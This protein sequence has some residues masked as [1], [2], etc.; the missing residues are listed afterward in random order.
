MTYEELIAELD[1]W[2]KDS[3]NCELVPPN[4]F[5][6]C[7][8][9]I[10]QLVKERDAAVADLKKCADCDYCK[11]LVDGDCTD[12]EHEECHSEHW[13]WRGVKEDEHEAD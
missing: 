10:E 11:W 2:Q 13:E 3:E 8:H 6:E 7:K 5:R 4:V 9:A 12:L 1:V